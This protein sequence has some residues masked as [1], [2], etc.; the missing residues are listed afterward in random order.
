MAKRKARIPEKAGQ[1]HEALEGVHDFIVKNKV[2]LLASFVILVLVVA[3]I[4]IYRKE[5]S[6]RRNKA[7]YELSK[8]QGLEDLENLE[9]NFSGTKAEVW[10]RL[11]L[12]D[13]FYE[14]GN[15]EGAAREYEKA[16][17]LPGLDIWVKKALHLNL[18]YAHEEMSKYEEAQRDLE[19]LIKLPGEDSWRN[20]A[21]IRLRLLEE[22]QNEKEKRSGEGGA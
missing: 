5:R 1:M 7:W 21:R 14:E 4:G 19:K 2:L 16:L 11:R 18:A 10:I 17:R 13:A 6:Q 8:A 9:Q 3:S 22:I 15:F 12:G 20:R